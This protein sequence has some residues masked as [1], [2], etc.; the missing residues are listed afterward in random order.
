MVVCWLLVG[1]CTADDG[2]VSEIQIKNFGSHALTG[3][4]KV[5]KTQ[6]RP[7]SLFFFFFV[8][9]R[10]CPLD[11]STDLSGRIWLQESVDLAVIIKTRNGR[12]LHFG[13]LNLYV[14]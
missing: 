1:K 14:I 8:K 12:G 13:N 6:L 7:Q 3:Y 4:Y 2:D 5:I 10:M 9:C 11:I